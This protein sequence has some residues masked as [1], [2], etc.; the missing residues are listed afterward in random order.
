MINEIWTP[1]G[2]Y[3]TEAHPDLD[4]LDK[5]IK[6][7]DPNLSVAVNRNTGDVCVFRDS[8]GYGKVP[9]VGWQRIPTV[10]EVVQK[11]YE[12]DAWRHGDKILTGSWAAHEKQKEEEKKPY[13]EAIQ[14][15]A[16]RFEYELR[17]R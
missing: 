2:V 7:A 17:E 3:F 12:M 5:H 13:Y 4:A 11:L 14:E 9:I 16:E 6:L 10:D 15:T 1:R 8:P